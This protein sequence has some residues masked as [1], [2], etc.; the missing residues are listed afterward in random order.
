MAFRHELFLLWILA[1]LFSRSRSGG[2][3]TPYALAF[4]ISHE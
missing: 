1:V 4:M 2:S 3:Q